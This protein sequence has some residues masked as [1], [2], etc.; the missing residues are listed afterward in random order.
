MEYKY[1]YK[2]HNTNTNTRNITKTVI[3]SG[4]HIQERKGKSR[5]LRR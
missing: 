5:K 3:L 2:A 1:I 4:G